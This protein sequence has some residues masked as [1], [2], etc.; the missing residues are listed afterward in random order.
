MLFKPGSGY[1]EDE[2]DKC[3]YPDDRQ[4][5]DNLTEE[6]ASR[7][8]QYDNTDD[9]PYTEAELLYP[10]CL[11]EYISRRRLCGFLRHCYVKSVEV[12]WRLARQAEW[13]YSVSERR[14]Q[15]L[16]QGL[17]QI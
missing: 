15:G 6:I 16:A 13:G 14:V 7:H 12:E 8:N 2:Y 3:S 11:R 1:T 4:C 17:A 10:L 9:G 5:G